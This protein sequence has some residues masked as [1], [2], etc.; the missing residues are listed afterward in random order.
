[1]DLASFKTNL[2]AEIEGVWV[3]IGEGCELLIARL[4]NKEF[5]KFMKS[6]SKPYRSMMRNDQLPDDVAEK[7]MVKA[8]AAT[9]L[10]DWKEL[11]LGGKKL[12]YS[13][14]ECERVLGDEEFKDF[15]DLVV[16][17]AQARETFRFEEIEAA[18]G[19]S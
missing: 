8:L 9:I 13:K 5:R 14:E 19:N 3:E 2:T 12:K 11:K 7:L 6:A 10:L 17:I 4:G 15:R 16:E 18:A 1:M